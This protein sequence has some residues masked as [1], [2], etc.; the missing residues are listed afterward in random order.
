MQQHGALGNHA[1]ATRIAFIEFAQ[2]EGAIAALGCTGAVLGA[3]A[4]RCFPSKTPVRSKGSHA[5]RFQA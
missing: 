5:A 2:P 1:A 3:R 4:L